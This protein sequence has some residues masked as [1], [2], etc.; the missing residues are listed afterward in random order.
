MKASGFFTFAKELLTL[1]TAAYH[2]H[3]VVAWIRQYLAHRE[4]L[5]CTADRFGNLHLSYRGSSKKSPTPI[6]ATAHLDHPGLG[7]VFTRR[8]QEFEFE[9]LGRLPASRIVGAPV[10]IYNVN[11]EE[12]ERCVRARITGRVTRTEP[13]FRVKADARHDTDLVGPG[14]FAV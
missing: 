13:R 2:E 12:A 6:M 4:Q 1:P 11:D 8:K 3:F 10:C 14:S 9:S 5:S 7:W